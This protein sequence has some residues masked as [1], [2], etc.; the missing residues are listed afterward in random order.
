MASINKH[1]MSRFWHAFYRDANGRQHSASTKIEHA[2]GG[3]TQKDIASKAANNRRLAQDIANQLEEAERGNA[4]EVHLRKLLADLSGRV[5]KQRL[6][7]KQTKTYLN[8]WMARAA[9][10]TLNKDG[11][12]NFH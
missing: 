2:P 12:S 4:T 6:E 5:N 10:E 9:K 7:F 11:F 8:D 1:P 3:G